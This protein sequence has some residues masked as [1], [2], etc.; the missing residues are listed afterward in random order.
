MDETGIAAPLVLRPDSDAIAVLTLNRPQARNSLSE[1]LI[2]APAHQFTAI[3]A[4][5]S[6]Q[7]CREVG[8]GGEARQAEGQPAT[9]AL[10]GC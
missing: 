9:K 10:I 7:N 3:A 4:D 5:R 1:A 6:A 8:A 2:A